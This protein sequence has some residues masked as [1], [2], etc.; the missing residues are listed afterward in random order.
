MMVDVAKDIDSTV[1]H[2]CGETHDGIIDG[3]AHG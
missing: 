1:G 2:R 3:D